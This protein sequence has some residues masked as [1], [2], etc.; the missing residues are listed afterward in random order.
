MIGKEPNEPQQMPMLPMP[1]DAPQRVQ[2]S[3]HPASDHPESKHKGERAADRP[4]E[5]KSSTRLVERRKAADLG[6]LEAMSLCPPLEDLSPAKRAVLARSIRDS[7]DPGDILIW[8]DKIIMGEERLQ[9]ALELGMSNGSIRYTVY[10][11]ANPGHAVM[12]RLTPHWSL[13]KGQRAVVTA[14]VYESQWQL[15]GRPRKS[16]SD[17]KTVQRMAEEADVKERIIKLAK[18]L[19]ASDKDLAAR[20][21]SGEMS[22]QK[23]LAMLRTQ[24]ECVVP[25]SSNSDPASATVDH[26]ERPVEKLTKA[27][28]VNL[29]RRLK[30]EMAAYQERVK[31][32]TDEVAREKR[33]ADIVEER[34]NRHPSLMAS[35]GVSVD[36]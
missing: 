35:V 28:L 20:V 10:E 11:G 18:S 25:G 12:G 31:E 6:S 27:E 3:D 16:G 2:S 30:E 21:V 22:L 17:E 23:A 15:T 7:G 24:T 34:V 19:V 1:E 8:K 36:V 13:G 33:R 9:I 26:G 4:P 29:V 5:K 32:L 14:W